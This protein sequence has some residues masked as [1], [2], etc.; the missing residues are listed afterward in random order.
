VEVERAERTRVTEQNRLRIALTTLA[1][2]ISVPEPIAVTEPLPPTARSASNEELLTQAYTQRQDLRAQEFAIEV[3]RQRKNLVV[4]RYFPQ[5]NARWQFPRLDPET[6]SNRDKFWTLFLDFEVPIFDGG[7]RELD[8]L[9]HKENLAQAKLEADRLRKDIQVEVRQA[10]LT[11]E[12]L[13][14]TLATLKKEVALAQENYDIT[15]KTYRVGLATSLDINTSLNALNQVRTQ[16]VNQAYA[17]QVA[18]LGLERA[19]GMFADATL[20]QG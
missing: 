10:F 6:F 9:E 19:V 14:A 16:L 13:E 18:V 5:V 4:A 1:R 3:A 8:L 20:P 2:A 17:Y 15:S 7:S 11:I 12:T